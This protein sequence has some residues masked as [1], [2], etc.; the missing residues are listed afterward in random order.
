METPVYDFVQSYIN[1][2]SVRL[3]MPGHK[4]KGLLE[5]EK[6]D[7]TEIPGA[8]SLYEA[9]GIIKKS[10]QNASKLFGCE[11]YFS[12]EG[13]SHCIRTMLF[14]I[15]QYA[16]EKGRVP[17]I[18]AARNVHKAFLS[19]VAL[20][21]I[22]V[23][24][25]YSANSSYLSCDIDAIELDFILAEMDEK[26]V[27]VYVTSPD[28]LGHIL[29]IES[30]SSVC[31]KYGVLLVVDNAHGAY[32]K[33]LNTSLHPIDC[34][35]DMC[36][37]SA[38]KTLPV[39]T[40][41]AYLHLSDYIAPFF[42]KKVKDV[43]CLFGSTSPSYLIL[44]SLDLA[45]KYIADN[46]EHKL[47]ELIVKIE[48]LKGKLIKHGIDILYTEPLKLTV[49]TKPYGYTGY[50]F[51]EILRH[52]N[53]ECEFAD[54]DF[55]VLMFTPEINDTD[56]MLLE[57]VF[58][59][60]PKLSSLCKKCPDF[61]MPTLMLSVKNAMFSLTEIIDVSDA[62]GRVLA[63]PGVSCPPAVPILMPGELITAESIEIYKYYGINKL[64]VIKS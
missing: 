24:W 23:E 46:Y 44:E 50:G 34:G 11:T 53:I 3:H 5:C 35:A 56:F 58:G 54:S 57:K 37:D 55:A 52:N 61:E 25:Y 31:H 64:T 47:F 15:S 32:L 33:F 13:S 39:L 30:V 63:S 1:R 51:A 62:E 9:D 49:S 22:C 40:G 6:Y 10:E 28:Y 48:R 36:C 21:D 41:G 38:H 4:G 16:K 14:L 20:T 17:L 43:L 27:A 19:A 29:D 26:P 42:D 8:D 59:A 18:L 60:I 2:D 45:N 12:T 7:I